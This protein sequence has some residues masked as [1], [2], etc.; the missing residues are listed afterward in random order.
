MF[1]F[2]WNKDGLGLNYKIKIDPTDTK[3]NAKKT[4]TK[5]N[6]EKKNI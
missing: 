3:K 1:H 4:Y 5:Q 2:E 6:V